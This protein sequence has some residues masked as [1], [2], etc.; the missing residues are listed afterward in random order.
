MGLKSHIDWYTHSHATLQQVLQQR[1]MTDCITDGN[2][3]HFAT[4]WIKIS[5]HYYVINDFASRMRVNIL[6][7]VHK[8]MHLK[9]FCEKIYNM[10]TLH[11]NQFIVNYIDT[12]TSKGT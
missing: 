9:F 12:T 3:H 4:V 6:I 1:F 5:R 10:K 2:N 7:S 11:P 8:K